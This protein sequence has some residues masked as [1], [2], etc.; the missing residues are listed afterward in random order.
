[1]LYLIPL[2]IIGL[3][4]YPPRFLLRYLHSEV[5][6][7]SESREQKIALTIDDAPTAQTEV[8]LEI[9]KKYQVTAT[10]FIIGGQVQ[11]STILQKIVAAGHELGNHTMWDLSLIHI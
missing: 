4:Y 8:I 7:Y 6:F 1:M 10:F 3:I 9:L 2:I 5:L 11:D